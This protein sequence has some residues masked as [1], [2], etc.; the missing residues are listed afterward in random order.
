MMACL[1][2]EEGPVPNG[3]WGF[4]NKALAER[5]MPGMVYPTSTIYRMV[6]AYGSPDRGA[7]AGVPS[8]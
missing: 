1:R 5:L 7:G 4:F 6:D 8:P 2:G 3:P